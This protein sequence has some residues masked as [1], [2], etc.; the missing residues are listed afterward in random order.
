[1]MTCSQAHVC[2]RLRVF[3]ASCESRRIMM[4]HLGLPGLHASLVHTS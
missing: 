4:L 2:H 1:M 3:N